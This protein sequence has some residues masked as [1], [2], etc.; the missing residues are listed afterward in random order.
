MSELYRH[1]LIPQDAM[2]VPE[3]DR[4]TRFFKKLE[5][6]QALPR[7]ANFT[8]ITRTGETRAWGKNANTGEVYYA[9]ATEGQPIS[10]ECS[11]D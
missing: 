9:P 8:V 7:E 5:D 1:L 6:L 10:V 11:R 2:F 4:I 3:L